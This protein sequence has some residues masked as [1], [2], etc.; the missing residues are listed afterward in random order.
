MDGFTDPCPAP[1]IEHAYLIDDRRIELYW[2]TQV[3]HADD[4]RYFEVSL[5][6]VAQP[7]VHWTRDMPWDYGTVYQKETYCTTLCLTEPIDTALA[8]RM[9]VRVVSE[10][11]D[12]L[13]RATDYQ[14]VYTLEYRPHY[15]SFRTT[16]DGIRIKG[17][18]V[19]Q[20]YTLDVAAKIIDIMLAKRPDVA[21]KLVERGAEIAVY[22]LKYDAYDVPEHRMGYMLATRPVEGFGGEADNPVGSISEAN[23]IRLRS[24]RYATRYP[25]EMILVHEFAHTFHLVGLNFLEDQTDADAVRAAYAHA[26]E[27]GKW[28]NSYAISNYEEYFATLSTIWFNV[29][30]E[31]IDGT[32]DGIRGPVNTREELEEYD[33]EGYALMARVYPEK[34]LP[35]PWRFNKDAYDITGRP[36]SYDL[37]VK[38]DWDFI[39]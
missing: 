13:D 8:S 32:W 22:G 39:G 37:D 6:G 28:G 34:S 20:S 27:A 38:F 4:E 3:F 17:S 25:H 15:T 18:K 16:R 33:P 1:E 23:V 11:R 35:Y 30:A 21:R 7:L 26:V 31:G 5:D 2:N 24:G 19:I 9:T 29:M 12:L 36:R 10:V 14:R